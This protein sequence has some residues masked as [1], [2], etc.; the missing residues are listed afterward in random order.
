MFPAVTVNGGITLGQATKFGAVTLGTTTLIN[1]SAVNGD[2]DFTGKVDATTA[3]V[4]ALT[5]TA[6]TGR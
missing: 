1:S 6:G 2:L 4:E 3:G 5:V